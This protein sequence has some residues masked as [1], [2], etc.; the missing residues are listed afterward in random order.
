MS[1]KRQQPQAPTL[2]VPRPTEG[3]AQ[4]RDL[5]GSNVDAWNSSLAN[6]LARAL[7][8][9]SD[10]FAKESQ[11]SEKIA[12]LVGVADCKP[13]DPIEGMLLAQI[14]SAN[15]TGLE[16]ARRAW[17]KDQTFEA[18]TKFLAL[19]D[20]SARTVATLVEALSRHRGKGQQKMTVEHVHVHAGA[21]AIVGPVTHQGGNVARSE[22][23]PHAKAI[24]HA[25]GATMLGQV[26]ADGEAMPIAGRA[27]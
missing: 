18:R 10:N 20:R 14:V 1:S 24:A 23:Q 25:P 26:E 21:Q 27:R 11:E 19:A 3:K 6:Y 16:L 5:G 4:L 22:E 7:P 13:A 2:E 15:A 9:S 8:T 17:I 12:A